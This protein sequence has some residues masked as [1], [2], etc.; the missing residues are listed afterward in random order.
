MPETDL[1]KRRI[2]VRTEERCLSCL[3]IE[4]SYKLAKKMEKERTNPVLGYRTAGSKAEIATGDMLYEEMK[5]IGLVNVRKDAFCVDSW[6]FE[7]AV[8]KFRDENGA[9]QICQMGGYQTNFETDGFEAFELVDLGK[10]TDADYQGIDVTGK[11]VLVEMNQRDEWWISF[12][13]YQ[14]YLKGAKALIAVQTMGYGQADENSLNA[15]DIAGPD[16]AAAFSISQADAGKLR[17]AMHVGKKGKK[18]IKVWLDAISKVKKNQTSYNI[19]GEIPGE[20]T[21]KMILLTAHY[22]SYFNGFQDDNA[23]VAMILGMARAI[24]RGGY[25]PAHTIVVCAM[26]AEE[27]GVID[28]K[29]D[30]ST[31]AYRQVFQ[32]RPQ[33]QGNVIAD[34]N[35]ELPA[36]AHSTVDAVRCTY[37]YADYLREVIREIQVPSDVYPEGM[38][39]L[40]PIETWSDDFS[41]AIAG[42]PSMVNNFSA[43]SFMEN[44]YHSQ[45]DNEDLYQEEVYEFHHRC[46]LQMILAADRLV[47]PPLDFSRTFKAVRDSIDRNICRKTQAEGE[48]LLVL[49]EQA[50]HKGD[51]VYQM[52]KACNLNYQNLDENQKTLYHKKYEDLF[53]KLLKIF[54]KT[55]DYFVRLN[56]NDEVI[57]PQE[58]VQN[59]LR[60]L[61]KALEALEHGDIEKAL[62]ALYGVDNNCYAFLFDEEVYYYFTEYI[63]HQP[64]ERLMWGAGRIMHHENLYGI[65]QRLRKKQ[66]ETTPVLN[67]EI[68]R[69][70]A[71]MRR[72]KAYYADDIHYLIQ[73]VKKLLGM[74]EQLER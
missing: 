59:N 47:L 31:G 13:V 61:K 49:L 17:S 57:F 56:W 27:W 1:E 64:Q 39:V 10:G 58:A 50:A 7:K 28:S 46:Y 15:Q 73:A 65:V 38:T 20:K 67:E 34:F 45:Y 6:E 21:D 4:Y 26:A 25:R 70:E 43:G 22:D 41:M 14:A 29:Y 5:A 42:I 30:W 23:A 19:V 54:R 53:E 32:V 72:Q 9:E 40:C 74:M 36:H 37:E 8:L 52:I 44:Y 71:A 69:L 12:P 63:L 24:I 55:Q 11:L 66:E 51:A 48:E 68:R 35:F 16:Y 62:E 3:D 18:E 2:D 33:W 60:E